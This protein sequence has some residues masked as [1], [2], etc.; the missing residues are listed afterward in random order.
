M[1][2]ERHRITISL[3]SKD[4][5]TLRRLARLQRAPMSRIVSELV[6]EVTP[7]LERVCAA[8]E[9]AAKANE[10]VKVSIRRAV[11]EA[12]Q[13]LL[14]HAQAVAR[15]FSDFEGQLR[16]LVGQ[17]DRLD[18]PEAV[19]ALTTACAVGGAAAGGKSPRPVT[20][21]ATKGQ[22]GQKDRTKGRGAA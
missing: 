22:R 1:A 14:P 4:Y 18:D 8:I 10:G 12:E 11:A 17:I 20:T 9:V 5:E 2:T 16:S 6:E 3:E 13:S 21:G 19:A 7:V 15:Q